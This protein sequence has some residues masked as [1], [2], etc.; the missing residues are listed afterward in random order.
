MPNTRAMPGVP[1]GRAALRIA[2]ALAAGAGAIPAP[3]Q[4]QT[5]GPSVT[6]G[7]SLGGSVRVRVE[8]IA[9]QARAGFNPGDTVY[10]SRTQLRLAWRRAHLRVVAELHDSREWGANPGTPL[11]TSEVNTLEP[12]QAYVQADLGDLLGQGTASSV[13]AGRFTLE[14]GSRRLIANDD[15]RNTTTGF[16][17]LRG[18]LLTAGGVRA[19]ALWALPLARLPDDGARLRR[20]AAELDREGF[21]VVLWG[22][23]LALQRKGSPLLREVSFLALREHDAPGR[24]TRDR[25]LDSLGLRV[26]REPVPGRLDWGAEAIMQWGTIS[27]TAQSGAARLPVRASFVRLHAGYSFAAPWR[28]H[29]LVEFD[30]ASGDGPGGRYGRF[31]PLYGMRRADLAPAGLFST[32]G[33][34]NVVSPGVRLEL[35]PSPRLDGFI[36]YRALWL[37]DPRDAFSTTGVRDLSGG[38]GRFAGHQID[39]RLRWWVLPRRLRLEANAV[40][41]AKGRFLRTAP[42]APAG[43]TTRYGSLSLAASF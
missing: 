18:D 1:V 34:T 4:A 3:A 24:P 29:L 11:S 8:T 10:E 40:L 22:G 15:F 39:S 20:N 27:A 23:F 14:L 43:A 25:A 36:G 42:G 12:V 21:D 9:G 26:L 31:D 33:R 32:V 19:T 38:A 17:G 41:L 13:Q 6:E 7:L 30:R 16:T 28:P 37:A 35:T 2:I 5:Q